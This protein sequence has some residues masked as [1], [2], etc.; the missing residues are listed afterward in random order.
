[1]IEIPG[2]TSRFSQP[3]SSDLL[4]NVYYTKNINFDL[5]G[6]IS[7][8]PRAIAWA[9]ETTNP[10]LRTPISVGLSSPDNFLLTTNQSF[11]F[12]ASN[13]FNTLIT[14]PGTN[15]PGGSTYSQ[16]IFYNNAWHVSTSNEVKSKTTGNWTTVISAGTLTALVKHPLGVFANTN[17][18]C[19]GDLNRVRSFNSSYSLVQTLELP[20]TYEVTGMAYNNSK[21]AVVTK[22]SFSALGQGQEAYFF[23][24]DGATA[25]ANQGYGVGATEIYS[26]IPYKSS[27]LILTNNGQLRYFNG[28]GF[29]DVGQFPVYF[30]DLVL[31]GVI[32]GV[33]MIPDGDV[34][35]I[36][37][38]T[39]TRSHGKKAQ[40]GFQNMPAGVWCYD[41]KVGIY[42]KYSPSISVK[43]WLFPETV[44][45]DECFT[46]SVFSTDAI[47]QTGDPVKYLN[48]SA[49][50]I[51]IGN[52]YYVIRVSPTR[53]RIALTREDALNGIAIDMTGL[54]NAGNYLSFIA[55]DFRDYGQSYVRN[56][57]GLAYNGFAQSFS[58]NFFFGG[59]I[60]NGEGADTKNHFCGVVNG[61]DNI[62]YM[63]TPKILADGQEDTIRNFLVSYKPLNGTDHIIIKHKEKEIES[64]PLI[65]PTAQTS[66]ATSTRCTWI[67]KNSFT[68]QSNISE[69][70]QYFLEGGD[71][72]AEIIAGVAGGE[73]SQITNIELTGETY[74]VTLQEEP[75]GVNIGKTSNVIFDNWKTIG[76]I[77]SDDKDEFKKI[78]VGLSSNWHQFKVILKGSDVSI[79]KIKIDNVGN[80]KI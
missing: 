29:E 72:E 18:L 21:L 24:W 28:G 25:Q 12:I 54:N 50:Q 68:T 64:I 27:F 37:L 5:E 62:G 42:H 73:I 53:F 34:V 58:A 13:T 11:N 67:S 26:V 71:V 52:V 1:M 16:G 77:T 9:N 43:Y 10:D 38:D 74:T 45:V 41:P 76:T 44:L 4:G 63:V 59:D 39:R 60:E 8:S 48:G 35:Y 70:Y 36:T 22:T 69:V 56:I 17:R 19:V 23:I 61:F 6:Y 49:P 15:T 14:D 30:T 40:S 7:L 32:Y 55:F 33:N 20:Q 2:T 65:T 66:T 80:T 3:N 51:S 57:G 31:E 47:P 78:P 75:I 79:R 46:Q